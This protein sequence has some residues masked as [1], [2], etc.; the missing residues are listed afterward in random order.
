MSQ[1]GPPV[2]LQARRRES[3][4]MADAILH[5]KDCYYFEVPKV[6]WPAHYTK[7][8]ELPPTLAF[9]KHEVEASHGKLTSR[10]LTPSLC[11]VLQLPL[12]LN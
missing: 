10:P 7:L 9:L 3:K 11:N 6:L 4:A 12:V 5:I 1:R 2:V 8:E